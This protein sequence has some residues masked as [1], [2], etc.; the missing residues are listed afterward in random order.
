M[1]DYK[2]ITGWIDDGPCR[3]TGILS[4]KDQL[5]LSVLSAV[6]VVEL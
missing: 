3:E 4:T 5:F 2:C 6:N 1:P